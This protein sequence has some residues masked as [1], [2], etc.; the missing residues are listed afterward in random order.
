MCME[1]DRRPHTH[2]PRNRQ[3]RCGRS[4]DALR[5]AAIISLA[6]GTTLTQAAQSDP[7]WPASRTT[8][9]NMTGTDDTTEQSQD[10][11]ILRRI[12][13][14]DPRGIELLYD[15]YGGMAYALA[16]RLLGERGMAEDVVQESF[17]S[18]WRL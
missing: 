16:Y 4:H 12:V 14:R 8:R 17:L 15:R 2:L 1:G 18:V 7:T 9:K 3:G 13:A 6:T 5:E 10:A 11:A